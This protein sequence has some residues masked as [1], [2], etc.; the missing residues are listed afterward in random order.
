MINDFGARV[1]SIWSELQPT[2]RRLVERALKS[3]P[4]TPKPVRNLPY[5]ALAETELS[6]LLAALDDRD[7]ETTQSPGRNQDLRHVADTCA[8][9]L[10]ER[11]Q[12]ADVFAQLVKRAERQH[13]YARIDSLANELARFAPSEI[14][15]LSRSSE[16]VIRALADEA[17]AQFPT[18]VLISLLNDPIDSEMAR[19]A[20]R[21][22][23]LEF[24][25]EEARQILVFLAQADVAEEEFQ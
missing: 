5:D 17:L 1:A 15:E 2:T 18:G 16:I 9:V 20:L 24:G 7:A 23:A 21:R 8:N 6:R 3:P 10:Q 19:H 4:S 22:Q 11:T 25:S 14:C 12:S 13:D